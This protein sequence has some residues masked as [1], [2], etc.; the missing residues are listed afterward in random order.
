MKPIEK[1]YT[2]EQDKDCCDGVSDIIQ[3]LTVQTQ[4]G[5][6]GN[7]IVLSTERWAIDRN[8]IDKFCEQLKSILEGME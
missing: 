4:D 8:D 7:F 1:S 6:G 2:F 5:G 3:L